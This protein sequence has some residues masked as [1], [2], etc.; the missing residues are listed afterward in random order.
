MKTTK[1]ILAVML[2]MVASMATAAD[3]PLSV[4]TYL[5]TSES[6]TTGT[7]N[8]ND[9]GNLG[10]IHKGETA[11]FTLTNASAQEMVLTF[12]TGN[13]NNSNPKVTVTASDGG[14]YSFASGTVA[15][16]NT[17]AWTP[18]TLHVFDLGTV[19]AGTI[20]LTFAF[21]NESGYVG[22]L[23]SIG[24]YN[25][26]AYI[27]SLDAMPGN[28]DL[29]KGNYSTARYND[30]GNGKVGWMSNGASCY[31]PSL[32]VSEAGYYSLNIGMTYNG[33]GTLNAKVVDETTGAVEVDKNITITSDVCHGLTT[34]TT[35][36]L[37]EVTTG[38]K[39]LKLTVSTSASYLID[40]QDLSLSK[41]YDGT[42]EV[43]GVSITGQS[44]T[45]GATSDWYC[46][47]PVSY[48][49]TTTFG[50][51]ATNGTIAVT[52]DNGGTVTVTDN[53][54]GT[55]TIPTPALNT[56]TTVTI[57]LTPNSGDYYTP[58]A[59]YTFKIFRIGEMSLTSVT[60][61]GVSA[62]VLTAI[63]TGD[64]YSATYSACYT[65]APTVAAVQIDGEAATVDAPSISGSTYTYDIHGSMAG[66]SITRNYTLVLDNVH[67]YAATGD[68]ESVNIKANEGTIESN[69][70]TNGIYTFA[71]T[72]LDSYNQFFKMNG[73][74]Y[75]LSVP[76]D[77]V[78]K[79]II[80]KDCSNNYVG[81]DARV[82][83][84]TS[85]GA[86]AYIPV[87]N[88]YYHDSEGSKHDIIVN[89]EGHAA[90]TDIVITQ[91]KKGQPMAWI[92]LTVV[93]Q[94]PGTDPASTAQSAT[95]SDNDAVVSVTFDREIA[96]D[97]TASI[98]GQTVNAKGGS[99]VLYFPVWDLPYSSNNTLTIAAG[100]ATDNY[101]RS[102][103]SAIEVAVNIPAKA[104]VTQAVYDYVVSS[105]AEFTAAVEAVNGSNTS[106]SSARKTIFIK[107]G[108][109]NLGSEVS[110]G[111]SLVQ[112]KCYNVSLIGESRDGVILYGETDGISNPV[113]N[114]RDHTG[115]YLQ[116]L[117]VKN[118]HDYGN[119]LFNGGVA[120]AIYG[121]DKTI[122]KNVRMLS[123]QDTQVTGHRA[124]FED[125]AI[126][127]TVDFI[128][129]G[130]DN[131]YYHTDLVL[132]NRGGNCITAPS[133]SSAHQ[134]G[135]VFDECT[136]KGV[137]DASAAT[138]AGS[139][140]LGRPW[141]NEPRA[142]FLNTDMQ[143]LCS[144]AGWADMSSL[145]THF[146]EYNTLHNGSAVDLSGRTNSPTSTNTYK[147]VLTDEEAAAFT[148]RNVLGGT[149]AWDAQADAA[150]VAA[151]Q[152][153]SANGR[154]LKW[155]AV[156][157]ALL[158]VV[159]KDG[160]YVANTTATTYDVTEDGIYTVK[161]ANKFGGLGAASAAVTIST[162]TYVRAFANAY[163][164]TLC[165]PYQIAT[166][167]G[168]T[169]YT[170]QYKEV[171]NE[172]VTN[173]VLDEVEADAPLAAG[174]PYF[175]LPNDGADELV[176]NYSGE[177]LENPLSAINGVQGI[178]ASQLVPENDYVTYQGQIRK[179]GDNVTLHEYRAYIRMDGVSDVPTPASVGRRR[180]SVR[181]IESTTGIEMTNASAI[182]GGS[183][184]L[185]N[186]Q[187][188]I[189]REGKTYNVLGT[190]L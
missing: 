190:Q 121:G 126:H 21:D 67:V 156:S 39:S 161:A 115:F 97:V 80:F 157:D 19:L 47:L 101:S 178:F 68:E 42:A 146:Y 90:G 73:D 70:W 27:A 89:L 185:R 125:C 91:Q 64:A 66:G 62:D 58:K 128:C 114:L 181:I 59:S 188:L 18:V 78:V 117:T 69:V 63:N 54:D 112:L 92:Q 45:A 174:T 1:H 94:N 152:N 102:N 127:G 177:A 49:E 162:G 86:T 65:T 186:G 95:I 189:L 51:T 14:S 108:E 173:I 170:L 122:M 133:T 148:V 116:D 79:Q 55:Y 33:D 16:P 85:V 9:N 165:F 131:F 149:D 41:A 142:Y 168:A 107:N 179:A 36:E 100:A 23:G 52:A 163:L 144:T 88:K 129:G 83:A 105:V 104:A 98:A 103:A 109:Y 22:N 159:F 130:G 57:T 50:V 93:K 166:Y 48:D 171:E 169:F 147:P 31:Y 137:D 183:K 134:W 96:N 120:V 3:I 25:K 158:Y 56:T 35:F 176:C 75:T 24:V 84:V 187:I 11:T 111:K 53:G 15:I 44:V 74:S 5:T 153:I 164:N 143:V 40:Y 34:P 10:N 145:P 32:Y 124:Y 12:K 2:T 28:I 151:P 138:N 140:N 167:T 119:G 38:Y 26:A 77:V 71:T 180:M 37:D 61:D 118:T 184:V 154:T 46:A 29:V 160:A 43:T 175:Y 7:I 106:A 139:Y 113:L 30:S 136:I 76:A 150:Q 6:V 155:N 81:N 8:N 72:S 141:Q 87:E 13:N 123:N 60:V 110:K 20:T 132:E 172:V 82:T 182:H 17:G 99:S 135:Y 4:G